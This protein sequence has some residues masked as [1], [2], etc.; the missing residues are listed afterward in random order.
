MPNAFLDFVAGS[1]K[2]TLSSKDGSPENGYSISLGIVKNNL[3]LLGEGRVTVRMPGLPAFD[4]H[5]R[6]CAVGGGGGRG[7]YGT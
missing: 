4:V 7:F 3:D 6:L 2:G 5:A 1:R